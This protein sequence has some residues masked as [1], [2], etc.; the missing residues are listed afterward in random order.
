MSDKFRRGLSDKFLNQLLHGPAADILDACKKAGLDVRLRANYINVYSAGRSLARLECRN[1]LPQLVIHHKY[2]PNEKIGAYQGK[3]EKAYCSFGVDADFATEYRAKL[4]SLVQRALPYQGPEEEIEFQLL[5]ANTG[6][7]GAFCLDRQIQVPGIR[8]KLDLIAVR[9][10][11]PALVLIEVKR[12]PD[13]RIQHVAKQLH[14]YLEIFDPTGA[15][16]RGDV[17][18]SYKTVC[19]QMKELELP[20]PDPSLISEGM[21]VEGLVVLSDYNAHSKLLDRARAQASILQR[22]MY[23]WRPEPGDFKMPDASSW[24]PGDGSAGFMDVPALSPPK[25]P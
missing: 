8:R 14:E 2:V 18:K 9:E 5:N 17:A 19:E 16:L 23:L 24:P 4:H 15:G 21:P 3:R 1:G 12:Y 7:T 6:S 13:P 10:D 22:P 25:A 20:A 11:R